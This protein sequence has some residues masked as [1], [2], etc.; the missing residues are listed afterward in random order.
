MINNK[1]IPLIILNGCGGVGKDTFVNICSE[2]LSLENYSTIDKYKFIAKHN[3]NW[4][5]IKDEKGRRLLS[6]LKLAGVRYNDAPL[7]ELIQTYDESNS[8]HLVDIFFCMCRDIEEIEKIKNHYPHAITAL[9]V[10]DNVEHISTN[11]GDDNVMNY[12]YD[13]VID[14]NGTLEDLK[15]T[16]KTFLENIFEC[17]I[18]DIEKGKDF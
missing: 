3:F 16:A 17:S 1:N 11:V 13:Y 9:I 18:E 8:C 14:N 2:Y 7:N 12:E 4:D 5:G 10:N 6:D 15:E